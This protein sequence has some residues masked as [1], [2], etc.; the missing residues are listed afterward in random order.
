MIG[1]ALN[2]SKFEAIAN[3]R[4]IWKLDDIRDELL[5]KQVLQQYSLVY[6]TQR[7]FSWAVFGAIC[8]RY[9]SI[10]LGYDVLVMN[11]L[12]VTERNWYWVRLV[13][14]TV[15]IA[16]YLFLIPTMDIIFIGACTTISTQFKMAN[17]IVRNIDYVSSSAS[18]SQK[19]FIRK[20]VDLHK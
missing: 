4:Y 19:R 7:A 6:K 15:T 11:N 8:P 16:M 3:K 14:Q 12:C 18:S 9:V 2:R 13:A 17:Y 10:A 20:Y 1:I 5:Q